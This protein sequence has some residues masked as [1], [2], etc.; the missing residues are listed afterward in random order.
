MIVQRSVHEQQRAGDI[1][2][3]LFGSRSLPVCNGFQHFALFGNDAARH[4][5]PEHAERIAHTVQGF[6]V[7]RELGGIGAFA[8][9][10]N[11]Q[12]FLDPQQV[13]LQRL[14]NGVQQHAIAAAHR[15]A[16]LLEFFRARQQR[17][18][19]VRLANLVAA[20]RAR[21]GLRQQIQQ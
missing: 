18:Q 10:E 12:C 20:R 1:Q 11:V 16:R 17:V 6:D 15:A 4:P 13:F 9:Q 2:Q 8:A 3:G 19:R 21:L 5:E 14:R 7:R